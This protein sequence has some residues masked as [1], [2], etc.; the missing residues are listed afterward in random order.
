MG[1]LPDMP[2]PPGTYP[3]ERRGPQ[4][5]FTGHSWLF[6]SGSCIEGGRGGLWVW[7]ETQVVSEG[8]L[9]SS[10]ARHS[11]PMAAWAPSHTCTAPRC[12]LSLPAAPPP[13]A[14]PLTQTLS[15]KSSCV[16]A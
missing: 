7:T 12:H 16:R 4:P 10:S 15:N 11:L 8:G 5:L 14:Q 6:Y 3:V 1:P 13:H 2:V 9:R